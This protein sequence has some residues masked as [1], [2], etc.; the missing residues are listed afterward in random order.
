MFSVSRSLFQLLVEKFMFSVSA[1]D[2]GSSGRKKMVDFGNCRLHTSMMVMKQTVLYGLYPPLDVNM[3]LSE[4]ACKESTINR[5]DWEGTGCEVKLT[6]FEALRRVIERRSHFLESAVAVNQ[7]RRRFTAIF[8][9][10]RSCLPSS[11]LLYT[12]DGE[13]DRRW[14]PSLP[15][16]TAAAVDRTEDDG[17]EVDTVDILR[18]SRTEEDLPLDSTAS[19]F[20][21]EKRTSPQQPATDELVDHHLRHSSVLCVG[22]QRRR[23][24]WSSHAAATAPH[25]RARKEEGSAITSHRC[26][27]VP[28]LTTTRAMRK[29]KAGETTCRR[30]RARDLHCCFA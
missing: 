29:G 17:G 18:H 15:L 23:A 21:R 19:W 13:K 24:P 20:G 10:C 22:K 26:R 5:K 7:R 2:L 12:A 14:I 6:A 28:P 25:Q 4:E 9:R 27:C 3:I 1:V 16:A 11:S 30:R 8:H